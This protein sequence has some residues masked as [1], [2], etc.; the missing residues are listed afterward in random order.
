MSDAVRLEREGDLAIL[1]IDN[2]PVNAIS[3]AVRAGLVKRLAEAAED[4]SITGIVL[5]AAGR[6]FPTGADIREFGQP[7]QEPTLPEV[8]TAIEE[9]P[10]PVV[11]ALH[12][13]A[14]GG[15]LELALAAHARIAAPQTMMGLPEVKLGILPGAGG[16]QRLPRLTGGAAALDLILSGQPIPAEKAQSLRILDAVADDPGALA[17]ERARTLS[18]STWRRTRDL[19]D[20]LGDPLAFRDAIDAART[21]EAETRIP[22]RRRIVDCIEAAQMLPFDMG[23]AFEREA[24]LDCRDSPEG[25]AL[26]HVFLAERAAAK[27]PRALPRVADLRGIGIL[28]GGT[29]GAGIALAA[30]MRGLKVVLAEVDEAAATRARMRIAKD[31][32]RM[33][34]QGR[35]PQSARDR[36]IANLTTTTDLAAVAAPPMVIEA[37]PDDL[38]LKLDVLEA[39]APHLRPR[40]V[41][42]TNTSYLDVEEI[43]D[44]LPDPSR[45]IGLHFFS[46]AHRN[47]LVEI[48]GIEN[49]ADEVLAAGQTLA[50]QLRKSPIW[51]GNDEGFVANAILTA[52]R[53][54][55]DHL[56]EDG[57][58]PYAI[59][60]ALR[61]FGFKLGPY[62]VLDLA[63]L[64]ISWRMRQRR[65]AQR[66]PAE[67][68]V[69]VG[70]LLCEAG[71]LGQK[72]GRGYYR[73]SP[74]APRG[75]EDPEVLRLIDTARR[76]AGLVPREVDA[77]EI[78]RTCLLA[79]VNRGA[80][81]LDTGTAARAGDI[82]VAAI[83]GLGF[84]REAGGPMQALAELGLAAALSE[85]EAKALGGDPFWRPADS[86]RVAAARG[87]WPA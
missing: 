47:P 41:V 78:V 50:R 84:P 29:M 63:G 58:S 70:D 13:H 74:D 24:F 31:I 9:S 72:A 19:V 54:A 61:G 66:T 25:R 62:Q 48:I 65:A 85:I 53:T 23:L 11:A 12:G 14:L 64:D 8:C 22:A 36:W 59:D 51:V 56:L 80:R 82:D 3:H 86:L 68:Y 2:P 5:T 35:V 49:T 45:M 37:V 75:A 52:Y 16:T 44:A 34:K 69:R 67:R 7:T 81:L 28:G 43:S 4:A 42:A 32:A 17:R 30:L 55:A 46:P 77:D 6:T 73:Y 71:R 21:A 1:I 27:P 76:E 87:D 57:A 33:V 10:K 38:D 26:R 79:M 39:L 40:S 20:G 60:A 18:R 15:G 83:L